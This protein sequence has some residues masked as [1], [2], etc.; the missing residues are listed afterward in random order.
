MTLLG[1]YNMV[2]FLT[3]IVMAVLII[4]AVWFLPVIGFNVLI[5]I[6]GAAG[7]IEFSRMFFTDSVERTSTV[8]AGLVCILAILSGIDAVGCLSVLAVEVFVL[9]LVFM[10]RTKEMIG[11][12]QR[13]SVAVFGVVYLGLCFPFWGWLRELSF[14]REIVFMALASACLCDTFGLIVGKKLGRHKFAPM[15]SPNKTME[16]FF[17]ALLGSLVGAFGIWWLMLAHVQWPFVLCLS[18]LVWITSPFGD[19]VESMLKR[20]C[21]V[22]DSGSI[23][24]GHGGIL[25]RLDA[26][27]FTAPVVYVFVRYVLGF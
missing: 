11:V 14:G 16:G 27:I 21:G 5:F 2:R 7:L 19:L 20:S 25:D 12:A 17:G 3:A 23:I 8:I 9:S 6:V 22:K 1:G 26:L 15:V 4:A 10:W 24:P 13:L 18:L